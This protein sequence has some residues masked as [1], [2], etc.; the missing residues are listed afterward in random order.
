MTGDLVD[1]NA[2]VSAVIRGTLEPSCLCERKQQN[3]F[4]KVAK[5]TFSQFIIQVKCCSVRRGYGCTPPRQPQLL[6][7]QS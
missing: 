2:G 6:L 7:S 1:I 5:R 3:E 4:S